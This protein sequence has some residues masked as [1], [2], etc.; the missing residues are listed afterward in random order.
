MPVTV[1][2]NQGDVASDVVSSFLTHTG[3]TS[4]LPVGALPRRQSNT[5]VREMDAGGPGP[6]AY[7]RTKPGWGARTQS[8]HS[9]SRG[10]LTANRRRKGAGEQACT[11]SGSN[12]RASPRAGRQGRGGGAPGMSQHIKPA[13]QL[14][15][16][17]TVHPAAIRGKDHPSPQNFHHSLSPRPRVPRRNPTMI[18]NYLVGTLGSSRKTMTFLPSTSR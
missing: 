12:V 11:S 6:H 2:G 17:A 14:H 8:A 15:A 5:R 9:S 18:E 10:P 7:R 4:R 3:N 13:C 1:N 16:L